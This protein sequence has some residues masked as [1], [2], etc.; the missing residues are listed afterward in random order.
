LAWKRDFA[1]SQGLLGL[2][3]WAIDQD[4]NDHSALNA[5]LG[6]LGSF[7]AQNGVGSYGSW[8]SSGGSCYFS[9]CAVTPRCEK[10]GY[11]QDGHVIRCD[12]GSHKA[13]CCPLDNMPD[14]EHCRWSGSN[15]GVLSA[16]ECKMS[17]KCVSGEVQIA[18]NDWYWDNGDAKCFDS[19]AKYCCEAVRSPSDISAIS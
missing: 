5:L 16:F 1:N 8:K 11:A 13:L 14:P 4:D 17:A 15:G 10:P 19:P 18:E 9:S 2:F 6:G 12:D 3:I 7:R